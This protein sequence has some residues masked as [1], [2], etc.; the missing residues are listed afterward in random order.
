MYNITNYFTM[1]YFFRLIAYVSVFFALGSVNVNFGK[2]QNNI[3][4]PMFS[5]NEGKIDNSL[6]RWHSDEKSNDYD[7]VFVADFSIGKG[8]EIPLNWEVERHS[9]HKGSI[10]GNSFFRILSPGNRFLPLLPKMST[11]I[12]NLE[13]DYTKIY[14]KNSNIFRLFYR[15]SEVKQEG[16]FVEIIIEEKNNFKVFRGI[17]NGRELYDREEISNGV[18]SCHEINLQVL[19]DMYQTKISL[20]GQRCSTFDTNYRIPST[21]AIEHGGARMQEVRLRSLNVSSSDNIKEYEI[22]PPVKI[23][24]PWD[25]HGMD[26]PITY[27]VSAIMRGDLTVLNISL[28]GGVIEQEKSSWFYY[29]RRKI[30]FLTRPYIR[31]M[32]KRYNLSDTTLILTAYQREYFYEILYNKPKWPLKHE[33]ILKEKLPEQ[34]IMAF[35]YDHYENYQVRHAEGGP[36]EVIVDMPSGEKLHQGKALSGYKENQF[37]IQIES[38]S[39][40]KIISLLPKDDPR[41]DLAKNFAKNNH[42]FVDSESCSFKVNIYSKDQQ[43]LHI[44]YQIENAFFEPLFESK[45]VNLSKNQTTNICQGVMKQSFFVDAGPLINGVYHLRIKILTGNNVITENYCA[46]EVISQDENSLSPPLESG[47]PYLYSN[48]NEMMN[49][50]IDYFDPWRGTNNLN[51]SHYISCSAFVPDVARENKVWKVLKIYKRDWWLWAHK[52]TAEHPGIEANKDLIAHADYLCL[53]NE[54]E[55]QP[56]YYPHHPFFG[57]QYKGQILK[58][59]IR[60]T[61]TLNLE[62]NSLLHPERLEHEKQLSAKGMEELVKTHWVEW[63]NFYS[64]TIKSYLQHEQKLVKDINPE[65]KKSQYGPFGIYSGCY[66]MGWCLN[67]RG[68]NPKYNPEEVMDGFFQLEDYPAWCRYSIGR[69]PLTM[70]AI[71]LVAPKLKIYPE[72]YTRTLEGCP[73]GAVFR[74]NPP[75]G[76]I[77]HIP[78]E[79]YKKRILEYVYGAVWHNEN[80]FDYWRDYGFHARNFSQEEFEI[81]LNT[82]KIV[83]DHKPVKPLRSSAYVYS[84]ECCREHITLYPEVINTA[85]EDIAFAWEMSRLNGNAGGFIS[86]MSSLEQ[87]SEDDTD[88]LILPPLKG[89]TNKELTEIRHLYSKG[90]S[91]IGFEDVTGLEDLFGVRLLDKPVSIN[92]IKV[93][94]E[95]KDNFLSNLDGLVEKTSHPACVA[96]YAAKEA[97]VLLEGEA[98]VLLQNNNT[99]LFNVPPTIIRRSEIFSPGMGTESISPLINKVMTQVTHKFGSPSITASEG[100]VLAFKDIKGNLIILV[101]ADFWPKAG[102]S[103]NP[104]I[105]INIKGLFPKQ[106]SCN[107]SYNF[108]EITSERIILQLSLDNADIAKIVISTEGE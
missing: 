75:Y 39:D 63:L 23:V 37:D 9:Q 81:L 8:N 66:K 94:T 69:G 88:C 36:A 60:F 96:K 31:L 19:T 93:N 68:L 45:V 32:G 54:Y 90:V 64:K 16:E 17:A 18:L 13:L 24:F 70:A 33:F 103:I 6:K 87:L 108:T 40:K 107:H 46:F 86:S 58:W 12:I 48:M 42:Y 38:P 28:S 5:D 2:N 47:L 82:W 1:K 105:T 25:I 27:S 20:N 22:F 79:L 29:H 100:R 11:Y 92:T 35:G 61:R 10:M 104:L 106:I 97:S 59:L 30:D 41:Y 26:I 95:L 43:D 4:S 80:G 3:L 83:R 101:Y 65:I 91:L 56:F 15:Y 71:K 34:F 67:Y 62:K 98:P 73:D 78:L 51:G 74:A 84:E 76:V 50:D 102:H 85:E 53:G 55:G 72:F 57:H 99:V 77:P 89:A 44:E 49:K 52:R 21:I 7:T 14:E